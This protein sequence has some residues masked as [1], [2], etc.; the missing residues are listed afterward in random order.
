MSSAE[1]GADRSYRSSSRGRCKRGRGGHGDEQKEKPHELRR[2]RKA[3]FCEIVDKDHG[4]KGD[5]K[6]SVF[7][8]AC[9]GLSYAVVG[10]PDEPCEED[11]TERAKLDIN[12]DVTVVAL[13]NRCIDLGPH[14]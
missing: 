11:Q 9:Y 8:I 4:E 6:R 1:S 3:A 14:I 2:P 5:S 7:R 10:R 12:V 13:L